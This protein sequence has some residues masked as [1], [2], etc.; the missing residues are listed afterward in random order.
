LKPIS[1]CDYIFRESFE[2]VKNKILTQEYWCPHMKRERC[3]EHR[4]KA[5]RRHSKMAVI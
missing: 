4:E 1:Q 3:H 5:M 2:K